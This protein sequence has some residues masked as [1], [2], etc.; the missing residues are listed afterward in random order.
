MP[1]A[2]LPPLALQTPDGTPLTLLRY[3]NA[4]GGPFR[5]E[6]DRFRVV[7]DLDAWRAAR[8]PVE[9]VALD[10][11]AGWVVL[12]DRVQPTN[13]VR[14]P[15]EWTVFPTGRPAAWRVA[16]A[17][18]ALARGRVAG[19]TS[20]TL[21]VEIVAESSFDPARHALPWANAVADLGVVQG[22]ERAFR[23]TYRWAILPRAFFHGLY[24]AIVFIGG[25]DRGYQGGLCTGMAR[26]ALRHAL[27]GEVPA[28]GAAALEEVL[29]LHGRQLTDRALLAA[30]RDVLRPSPRRAYLRFRDDLLARGSS[31]V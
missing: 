11:P 15:L 21:P 6:P 1:A 29:V 12:P 17:A 19:T 14:G 13:G 20:A 18:R 10:L 2:P 28:T 26:A 31:D 5:Y 4:R 8:P 7:V 23:E 30:A 27:G 16:L 25:A 9:R 3:R 24:R 22:D